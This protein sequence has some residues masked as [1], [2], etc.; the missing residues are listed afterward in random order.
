MSES[1]QAAWVPYGRTLKEMRL[2]AG[3]TC[4]ALAQEAACAESLIS[5][6]ENGKRRVSGQV[7]RQLAAALIAEHID[8]AD[9]RLRHA[10]IRAHQASQYTWH[11]DIADLEA[12]ADTM[13]IWEPLLVPGVLQTNAYARTVFSE[14]RPQATTEEVSQLVEDRMERVRAVATKQ[15]WAI[16]DENAL[17]R[18]VGGHRAM[19]EQIRHLISRPSP[20][21]KVTIFP[22]A[23]PYCGGLAGSIILLDT[24]DGLSAYAEHTS[25]GDI[26][27]D[28]SEIA[29]ISAVWREISAWA[30][31]PAESITAMEAAV[32]HHESKGG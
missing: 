12:A 2:Q 13:T 26:I 15:I 24:M 23:S 19:A 4:R 1:I 5:K 20:R 30:L 31:S 8:D 10:H 28:R 27:Y 14:G 22:R 21:H 18:P 32:K 17:Y 3:L 29:R 6:I 7:N 11:T 16:L 25:G 9:Q